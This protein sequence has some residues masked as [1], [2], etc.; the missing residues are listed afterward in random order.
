MEL[1]INATRS[2]VFD[3]GDKFY[4]CDKKVRVLQAFKKWIKK[5]RLKPSGLIEVYAYD[6]KCV[7]SHFT[8]KSEYR[9]LYQGRLTLQSVQPML[10][11]FLKSPPW[12]Y[13][14]WS[15]VTEIVKLLNYCDTVWR[16]YCTGF[17]MN[18]S[19]VLILLFLDFFGINARPLQLSIKIQHYLE[20][21]CSAHMQI[22]MKIQL[23]N[24][25][26]SY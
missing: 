3:L 4:F 23:H 10:N 1:N 13:K 17:Q 7:L 21:Y 16:T 24:T 8:T 11:D 2:H 15:N 5:W 19:R 9:T 25:K 12:N 26:C 20:E 18:Y 6:W 22:T 14:Q